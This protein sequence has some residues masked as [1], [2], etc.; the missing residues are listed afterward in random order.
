MK[1]IL[2]RGYN[3]G[4]HTSQIMF[5]IFCILLISALQLFF[6]VNSPEKKWIKIKS[7]MKRVGFIQ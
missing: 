2:K 5:H 4:K 3:K 6:L 1:N 7:K